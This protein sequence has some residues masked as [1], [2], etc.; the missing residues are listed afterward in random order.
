MQEGGVNLWLGYA[1][2]AIHSLNMMA[3]AASRATW[4]EASRVHCGLIVHRSWEPFDP[5]FLNHGREGWV[6][7]PLLVHRRFHVTEF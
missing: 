4:R 3:K 6:H 2:R 1:Y 7:V 5:L